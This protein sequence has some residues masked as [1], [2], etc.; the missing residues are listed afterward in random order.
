MVSDDARSDAV[1]G[2]LGLALGLG[3]LLVGLGVLGWQVYHWLDTAMW[4][5]RSVL[6]LLGWANVQSE[7]VQNPTRWIGLWRLFDW[8]PLSATAIVFGAAYLG[9]S[10]F[11]LAPARDPTRY[12]IWNDGLDR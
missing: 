10:L 6:D 9:F 8:L 7:W 2:I 11:A 12:A 1:L 4:T 5:S 3:P